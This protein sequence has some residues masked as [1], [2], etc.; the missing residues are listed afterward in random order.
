[1]AIR[2]SVLRHEPKLIDV[3]VATRQSTLGDLIVALTDEASQFV[4]GKE[5]IYRVVAYY[6]VSDILFKSRVVSASWH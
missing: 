5:E 3:P 2:A 4:R 6:M 1:V